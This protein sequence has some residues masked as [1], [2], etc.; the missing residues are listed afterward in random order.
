MIKHPPEPPEFPKDLVRHTFSIGENLLGYFEV[1]GTARTYEAR[2]SQTPVFW[3]LKFLFMI[4]G[5]TWLFRLLRHLQQ[6]ELFDSRGARALKQVALAMIAC[7]ILGWIVETT[8]LFDL[9]R[10]TFSFSLVCMA[11]LLLLGSG[12]NL[13]GIAVYFVAWIMEEAI[14][15]QQ[16]HQLTV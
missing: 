8:V 6:G 12:W 2:Y 16:E 14:T 7:G 1:E 15:V 3:L 13:I 10:E 9:M 11:L 5:V 4:Y